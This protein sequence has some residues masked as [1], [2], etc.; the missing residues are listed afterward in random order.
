MLT[1]ILTQLCSVQLNIIHV[2][3]VALLSGLY[4]RMI[5]PV[6]DLGLV[7]FFASVC[8]VFSDIQSQDTTTEDMHFTCTNTL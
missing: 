4:L 8:L 5:W 3:F 2:T 6:F 1:C 7:Y